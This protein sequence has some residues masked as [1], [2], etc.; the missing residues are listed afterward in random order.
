M[1]VYKLDRFSRNKYEMAIHRKHL[2]D[3]GIKILSAKE[4]IPETP[5][6]VLLESLLEGMNQYY[7]EELSQKTKR[8]MR[9]TRI[10]GN[11]IGGNINY[12]YS[13]KELTADVNGKAVR[14]A[15]K[16]IIN[17]QEAPILLQI[18]T[19]YANGKRM[20]EIVKELH[21]KGILNRGKPFSP[22]T[23]YAMLQQEKYTGI[24][25]IH[26]EIYDKIYPPIIPKD[27]FQVVKARIDANKYGKHV[28]GVD[29]ILKGR[30]FCGYCGKAL[31]SAT[32]TSKDTTI[33]RYYKCPS[34]KK[35]T[36]CQNKAMKKATL[37]QFVID[38]LFK[39]IVKPANI[40]L[41]VKGILEKHK[42]KLSDDTDLRYYEREL[43]TTNKALSN[44][45]AAIE[46][47]IF[48]ETTKDRLQELEEKK[49]HLEENILVE[50]ARVKEALSEK[51]IIQRIT[52]ALKLKAKQAIEMLIQRVDV[53]KDRLRITLKYADGSPTD[54]P[55][56]KETDNPY[57]NDSCRGFILSYDEQ[58][59]VYHART[60]KYKGFREYRSIRTLKVEITI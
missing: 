57:G 31:R 29:Y 27:L 25:R 2:K 55:P 46:A 3:N 8:G 11:F 5:E 47:G 35:N 17:E 32:G 59:E 10:K 24:Y 12:G 56:D 18:F 4:N 54:T 9:E 48:T 60:Y 49:H 28:V 45:V 52:S 40:E 6:G 39:R 7:S 23:I 58:Y 13:L 53:F 38:A 20:R 43:A 26:D 51:D 1:T 37:E 33:W 44:I 22:M 19:D 21:D 50:K 16:V 34:I 42:K 36:G 30:V 41:L 14:T 15:L